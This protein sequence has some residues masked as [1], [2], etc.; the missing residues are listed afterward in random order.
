[1]LISFRD[2]ERVRESI[3]DSIKD[4]NKIDKESEDFWKDKKFV[5]PIINKSPKCSD[6]WEFEE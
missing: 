2:L 4:I 5:I 6:T 1:M 3:N